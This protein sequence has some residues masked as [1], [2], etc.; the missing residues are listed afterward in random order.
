MMREAQ[1]KEIM[2]FRETLITMSSVLWM[3]ITHEVLQREK[4]NVFRQKQTP[5][6][7]SMTMAWKYYQKSSVVKNI[8]CGSVL[9]S[10]P[11]KKFR[12]HKMLN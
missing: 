10:N 8:G 3:H 9:C 6:T 11:S 4:K 1:T 7:A 5:A 12:D 2:P